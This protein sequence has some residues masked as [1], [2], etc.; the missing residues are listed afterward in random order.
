[1]AGGTAIKS[2]SLLHTEETRFTVTLLLQ[3][4]FF[5]PGE[6]PITVSYKKILLIGPP[7]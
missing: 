5:C 1:M 3:P 6:T 7:H 4:V 2:T